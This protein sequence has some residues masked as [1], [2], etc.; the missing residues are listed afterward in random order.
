M[1]HE[2]PIMLCYPRNIHN[3]SP[4]FTGTCCAVHGDMGPLGLS[5]CPAALL[6]PGRF[7]FCIIPLY[8]KVL[9]NPTGFSWGLTCVVH[10]VH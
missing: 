6:H 9:Q 2:C 7:T 8:T 3:I 1:E 10:L 4:L 5:S